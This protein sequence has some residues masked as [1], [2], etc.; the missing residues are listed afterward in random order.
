MHTIL[1]TV[2]VYPL[3][4]AYAALLGLFC[5]AHPDLAMWKWFAAPGRMALTNYIFQS[6]IGIIL[7]YGI[8]IG[9]GASLGLAQTEIAATGVFT[10]QILFSKIWLRYFQYGPLEWV[11]RMLTYGKWLKIL[12]SDPHNRQTAD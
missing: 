3:G 1:Y 5:I 6:V 10:F 7:F 4:G 11:W 2:S 8:G 12:K 9:L